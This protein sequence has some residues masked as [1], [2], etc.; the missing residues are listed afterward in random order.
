M[1]PNSTDDLICQFTTEYVVDIPALR[2]ALCEYS[3]RMIRM[4]VNLFTL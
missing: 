4:C 2:S 3:R 1:C